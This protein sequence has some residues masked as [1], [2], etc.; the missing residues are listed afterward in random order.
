MAA[1]VIYSI[2][3]IY[4]QTKQCC[5]LCLKMN[6]IHVREIYCDLISA[7]NLA[8]AWFSILLL[9]NECIKHSTI[10]AVLKHCLLS[11]NFI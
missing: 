3:Y 10:N 11:N 8:G 5:H 1:I 7:S 9:S 2:S 4:D 6:A